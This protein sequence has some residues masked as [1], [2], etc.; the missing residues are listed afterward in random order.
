MDIVNIS[1]YLPV[2]HKDGLLSG[3]GLCLNSYYLICLHSQKTLCEELMRRPEATRLK[4]P[5][6]VRLPWSH[7][8]PLGARPSRAG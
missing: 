3:G 8:H 7:S 6:L 1:F 2:A 4:K 5:R